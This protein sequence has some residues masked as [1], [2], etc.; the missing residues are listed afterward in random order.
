MTAALARFVEAHGRAILL[1]VLSFAIAGGVFMFQLPVSIFPQTD[2]PRVVVFYGAGDGLRA[3]E[4]PAWKNVLRLKAKNNGGDGDE[5]RSIGFRNFRSSMARG[6]F[7]QER[8]RTEIEG[9]PDSL[10][11]PT[12]RNRIP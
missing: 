8:E 1:V 9:V 6:L 12:S 4:R 5:P 11:W 3:H 10:P 2:F 7:V